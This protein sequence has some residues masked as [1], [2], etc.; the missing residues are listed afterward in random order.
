MERQKELREILDTIMAW[1]AETDLL[2]RQDILPENNI[3]AVEIR[4]RLDQVET[5]R[6][7]NGVLAWALRQVLT[8]QMQNGVQPTRGV[9]RK[10]EVVREL[11]NVI[12]LCTI[13]IREIENR[14]DAPPTSVIGKL[15]Q[16]TKIIVN[17]R[18]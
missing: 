16:Y 9:Y 15:K 13:W 6:D 7:W 18:K 10:E 11:L 3:S 5:H 8:A 1:C 4:G 2:K 14:P 17:V 12:A